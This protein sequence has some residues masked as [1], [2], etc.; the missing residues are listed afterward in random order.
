[1]NMSETQGQP[2]GPSGEPGPSGA[3]EPAIRTRRSLGPRAGAEPEPRKTW[4]HRTIDLLKTLLWVI[5]LTVLV[6]LYAEREQEVTAE[7]VVAAIRVKTTAPDIIV[8]VVDQPQ[9]RLDLRGARSN[10]DD[11]RELL[12]DGAG[13]PLE[14]V[15]DNL[16]PGSETVY[17]NITEALRGNE[18]FTSRAVRVEGVRPS[19]IR[20]NVERKESHKARVRAQ[21]SSATMDV[22][23]DPPT[24]TL[25]GPASGFAGLKESDL[26]VTADMSKFASLGPGAHGSEDVPVEFDSSTNSAIMLSRATVRATVTVRESE[27]LE[28]ERVTVKVLLPA[29]ALSTDYKFAVNKV[30]L[31]NVI[32]S[33]TPEGIAQIKSGSF[34]PSVIIEL[35]PD[36]YAQTGEIP[37]RLTLDNF[38]LPPN[39]TV[40]NIE[41]FGEV[42]VSVTR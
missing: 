28:L 31:T 16:K 29:V 11:I 26:F 20:L 32:L 3:N 38:R 33:G 27:T 9:I 6:W 34:T 42:R 8:T 23:F 7:N 40:K 22:V 24:V 37:K 14:I 35:T 15:A 30:T 21:S 39:V 12:L 4:R 10:L 19:S 25:E 1:M 36:N 17:N 2:Q 5:P 13:R 18:V 41:S